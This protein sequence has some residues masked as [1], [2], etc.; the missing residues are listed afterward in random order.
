MVSCLPSISPLKTT[1]PFFLSSIFKKNNKGQH[2]HTLIPLKWQHVLPLPLRGYVITWQGS[3]SPFNW[4][5]R[6]VGPGSYKKHMAPRRKEE[7]MHESRLDLWLF[8]LI[9]TILLLLNF[10]GCAYRSSTVIC[11]QC[12]RPAFDSW[13]RKIPWR[14]EGQPTPVVLPGEF[15]GQRSLAGYGVTKSWTWLDGTQLQ[16]SCLENPMD[17][18]AW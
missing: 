17:G 9:N 8:L 3:L 4:E 12:G 6:V 2:Y 14:T 15:P 10:L 5:V 18:G 7:S 16:Y 11:L 13:I 1:Q